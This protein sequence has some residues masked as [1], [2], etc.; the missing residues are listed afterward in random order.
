M[1]VNI[2]ITYLEPLDIQQMGQLLTKLKVSGIYFL[3]NS[4][5]KPI[6]SEFNPYDHEVVY[7]G[8]AI[9][10][11][12]YSRTRKHFATIR[13]TPPPKTKPGKRF[14]KYR[15]E[16][17]YDAS[18]HWVIAGVMD[19]NKPYEISYVE[20]Y[21]IAEYQRTN[22]GDPPRANTAHHKIIYKNGNQ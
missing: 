17:G 12:I 19:E 5:R 8:K 9:S 16:Q 15:E 11:T 18:N 10:E 1:S 7:I 21:L 6:L 2:D 14:I 3:V 13:N 22:N 4:I 20:E